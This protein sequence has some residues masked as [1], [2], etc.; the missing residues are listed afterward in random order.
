MPWFLF[1][2]LLHFPLY[3]EQNK[4]DKYKHVVAPDQDFKKMDIFEAPDEL[5]RYS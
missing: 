4:N 1:R 2:I 5:Q 3:Q